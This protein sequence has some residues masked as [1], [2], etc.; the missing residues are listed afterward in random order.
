MLLIQAC[1]SFFLFL[2][3]KEWLQF[4]L[5]LFI[6]GIFITFSFVTTD[7]IHLILFPTLK[8]WSFP[9]AFIGQFII[10]YA[11]LQFTKTYFAYQP[12]KRTKWFI[13]CYLLVFA[14]LV[15][16]SVFQ[17]ELMNSDFYYNSSSILLLFVVLFASVLIYVAKK[18]SRTSKV[19]F[20]IAFLQF[21]AVCYCFN[22][23]VTRIKCGA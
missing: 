12:S 20:A 14:L 6:L 4:Y 10:A 23:D 18:I 21:I 8:D 5:S 16:V 13:S 7:S 1:Y 3:G 17:I 22:V 2:I 11:L 19:F 9:M 15:L